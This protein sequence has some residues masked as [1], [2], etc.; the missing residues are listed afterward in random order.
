L[1][2]RLLGG[3]LFQGGRYRNGDSVQ[4]VAVFLCL[5]YLVGGAAYGR[6]SCGRGALVAG[7]S[8]WE[9]PLAAI[10]FQTI[11]AG[12]TSYKNHNQNP[13]RGSRLLQ[14]IIYLLLSFRGLICGRNFLWVGLMWKG[15]PVGGS[16]CGRTF[17]VGGATGRDVFSI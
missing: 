17:F 1:A 6:A 11:A 12:R 5:K 14:E 16:T 13:R 3:D 9:G 10:F 4:E 7:P 2:Q 15:I 8:L